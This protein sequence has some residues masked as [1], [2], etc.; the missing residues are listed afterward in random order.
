M[1]AAK[2]VLAPPEELTEGFIA[3]L[4]RR[5][6]S[7][8]KRAIEK[9]RGVFDAIARLIYVDGGLLAVKQTFV[10][11]HETGH[12]VIPHQKGIYAVME[13]CEKTL[14][15]EIAELFER[16]ANVFASEV[17]FQLDGFMTEARDDPFGIGVPLRLS[18]RYGS[19]C[20]A[21]IRQYVSKSDRACVVLVL[22][23]PELLDGMGIRANIRRVVPS[24]AFATRFSDLTW[25]GY[26]SSADEIGNMIPLGQRRMSRPQ[27]ISLRDSNGT[28]HECVAEA[29]RNSYSCFV[30]IH[31]L[32]TMTRT[33][34]M[35]STGA[36]L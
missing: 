26:V 19:S 2:V 10:K 24:P 7:G 20:Y 32:R 6:A 34:A 21:A 15:P 22:D 9:V 8:L 31:S 18:K 17:L 5:F 23:P 16:E 29:F 12:A 11:L 3:G 35:I 4:R 13:D 30:L 1:A 27:T 14:E 33:H 25:P 36:A 28:P